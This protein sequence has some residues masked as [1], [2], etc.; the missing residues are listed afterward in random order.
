[1]SASHLTSRV[2]LL[3][4]AAADRRESDRGDFSV[5]CFASFAAID[6]QHTARGNPALTRAPAALHARVN[7]AVRVRSLGGA[8]TLAADSERPAVWARRFAAGGVDGWR[9]LSVAAG[10]PPPLTGRCRCTQRSANGQWL[11]CC[12]TGRSVTIDGTAAAALCAHRTVLL[13]LSLS[14]LSAFL[15]RTPLHPRSIITPPSFPLPLLA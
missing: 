10:R 15:P 8:I 6:K 9:R 11:F 5:L 13:C 4:S 14:L 1:M 3:L 2:A 7:E 12:W